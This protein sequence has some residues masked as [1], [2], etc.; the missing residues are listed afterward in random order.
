MPAVNKGSLAAML[1]IAAAGGLALG[2]L[3]GGLAGYRMGR[4]P[5]TEPA[6]DKAV[7]AGPA[8]RTGVLSRKD[9][10]AAVRGKTKEQIIAAVG[11]PDDTHTQ[12][13]DVKVVTATGE[14]TGR[15]MGHVDFE[16]WVFRGRV[17]ND[18]TGKPYPEVAVRIGGSDKADLIEYP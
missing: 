8:A 3:G 6:G 13:E 15:R 2:C 7:A 18:A 10:E 11:R 9:F 17:L 12:R 1:G 4:T 14:D 5:G 16:W